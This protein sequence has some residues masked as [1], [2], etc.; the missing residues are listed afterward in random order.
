MIKTNMKEK[1]ENST[2]NGKLGIRD[3]KMLKKA[4]GLGGTLYPYWQV[5]N[6]PG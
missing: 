3:Y 1:K 4:Y 6:T 2:Q 5:K